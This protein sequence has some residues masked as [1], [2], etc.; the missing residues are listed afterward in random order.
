MRN[1][2][3]DQVK[4]I[5]TIIYPNSKIHVGKDLSLGDPG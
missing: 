3:C 1:T 5:Y 2:E 4:V